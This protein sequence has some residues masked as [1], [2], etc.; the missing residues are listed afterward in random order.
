MVEA[1]NIEEEYRMFLLAERKTLQAEIAKQMYELSNQMG[2]AQISLKSGEAVHDY[3]STDGHK[4][5]SKTAFFTE[6][7]VL[8]SPDG[9]HA[10]MNAFHSTCKQ[11]ANEARASIRDAVLDMYLQKDLSRKCNLGYGQE[12]F[13]QLTVEHDELLQERRNLMELH[14]EQLHELWQEMRQVEG[15]NLMELKELQENCQRTL[16]ERKGLQELLAEQHHELVNDLKKMRMM[17]Q[18]RSEFNGSSNE[19][20]ISNSA[21]HGGQY[22]FCTEEPD[23]KQG[24]LQ[25]AALGKNNAWCSIQQLAGKLSKDLM[26]DDP[27]VVTLTESTIPYTSTTGSKESL[28]ELWCVD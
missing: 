10:S 13:V 23:D 11:R 21:P 22:T 15:A 12:E 20:V 26:C 18:G 5:T 27:E 17:P 7:T 14:A 8:H 6:G 25:P 28:P 9:E 3:A 16:C 1:F 2:Q 24:S 19:H 4:H